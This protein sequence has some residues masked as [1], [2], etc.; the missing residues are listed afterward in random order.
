MKMMSEEGVVIIPKN[1][2]VQKEIGVFVL[3]LLYSIFF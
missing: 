3:G 2:V 1:E